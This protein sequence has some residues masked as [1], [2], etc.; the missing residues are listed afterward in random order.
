MARLPLTARTRRR[1]MA[2]RNILT[3]IVVIYYY[4]WLLMGLTYKRKCLKIERRL[5]NAERRSE[6]LNDLVQDSDTTCISELCMDI[7]TFYILCEMLRDV[8]GLK[9][10]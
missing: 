8:G 1:N 9:S 3:S 7:R 6:N 5:R 2:I 10:T 4:V